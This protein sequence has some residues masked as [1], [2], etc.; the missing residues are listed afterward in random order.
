MPKGTEAD[1]NEALKGYYEAACKLSKVTPVSAPTCQRLS[2]P[3][4]Q[5]FSWTA[6]GKPGDTLE[7]SLKAIVEARVAGWDL[8]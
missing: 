3:D 2:Q 5:G 8:I 4:A 1:I 6:T 7:E